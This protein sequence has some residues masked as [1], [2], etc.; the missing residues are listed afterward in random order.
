MITLNYIYQKMISLIFYLLPYNVSIAAITHPPGVE[1]ARSAA[2][3]KKTWPR[4]YKTFSMLNLAEHEIF[5][6]HK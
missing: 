2:S 5:P 4:G 6:A 3:L 1:F